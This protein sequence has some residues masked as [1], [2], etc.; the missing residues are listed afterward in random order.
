[1]YFY[2]SLMFYIYFFQIKKGYHVMKRQ[3]TSLRS[4]IISKCTKLFLITPRF[5]KFTTGGIESMKYVW[6]L[7]ILSIMTL[8]KLG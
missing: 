5:F 8:R 3:Y 2:Y 1:M 6:S 7:P 4:R